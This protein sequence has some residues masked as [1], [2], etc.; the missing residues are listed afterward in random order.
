[1]SSKGEARRLIE[2]NAIKIDGKKIDNI[3]AAV[4]LSSKTAIV[5]RAGKRKFLK[6]IYGK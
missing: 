6:A 4:H 1:M 2:Q 3:N 5:I